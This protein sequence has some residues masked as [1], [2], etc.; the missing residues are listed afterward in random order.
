[1]RF[2]AQMIKTL[3]MIAIA[4]LFCYGMISIMFNW[5]GRSILKCG[6]CWLLSMILAY[7]HMAIV[8][9]PPDDK[10]NKK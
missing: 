8:V 3:L 5:S 6:I 9:L 4:I 7:I 10:K 2:L 1:M